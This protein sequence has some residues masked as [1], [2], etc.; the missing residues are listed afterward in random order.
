MFNHH[1]IKRWKITN[2][3]AHTSGY[4][5]TTGTY[6]LLGYKYMYYEHLKLFWYRNYGS[7]SQAYALN[8]T[9]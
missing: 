7:I 6:S 5:I 1:H 4:D 8:I 9:T 3:L 2:A